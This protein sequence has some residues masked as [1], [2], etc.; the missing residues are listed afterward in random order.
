MQSVSFLT[1]EWRHLLMLNYAIDP[2][3]LAPYVPPGTELDYYQGTTFVS[4]VGFQFL[5]TRVMGVAIPWHRNFE[6]VNLRFYVRHRSS[7]GWR[8]GVVF[9]R[10]LVPRW[11]IAAVAR[12]CY[13][14]AYRALPMRHTLRVNPD[15]IFVEYEWRN[16]QRW[17]SI[18]AQG[19]GTPQLVHQ[20][21]IEEFITEHYW[22]YTG[23]RD[24]CTEYQVE[25]P[26]WK[27]WRATRPILDAHVASLYG[28][29]FVKS[30]S[31][32]PVSTFI[33]EGSEV[34]VRRKNLLRVPARDEV[35]TGSAAHHQQ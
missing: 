33:A 19:D 8:R 18:S 7:D 12:I 23:Q 9:V 10:E 16:G 30:L 3:V 28:P 21:S 22:G 17:E 20:G 6:E 13:G 35:G 27:V 1:A 2:A 34:T 4:V 14:E 25:H 11:A 15:G 32:P 24:C 29:P 31:T 5:K 26:R